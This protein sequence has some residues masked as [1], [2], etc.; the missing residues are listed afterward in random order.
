MKKIKGMVVVL[1]TIVIVLCGCHIKNENLIDK[2]MTK[3]MVRI[4]NKDFSENNI[5]ARADLHHNN[6]DN[7]YSCIVNYYDEYGKVELSY[8]IE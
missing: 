2:Y 7:S 5:K 6:T 8:T 4:L 1:S 3:R